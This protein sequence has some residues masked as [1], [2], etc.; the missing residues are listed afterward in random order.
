MKVFSIKGFFEILV[1]S[2]LSVSLFTFHYNRASYQLQNRLRGKTVNQVTSS[3]TVENRSSSAASDLRRALTSSKARPDNLTSF[4]ERGEILDT[5]EKPA[6]RPGM[7]VRSKLLKT[8]FK[9]PYVRTQETVVK[10]TQFNTEEILDQAVMVGDHLL[11]HLKPGASVAGLSRVAD[12]LGG[13]VLSKLPETETYIVSFEATKA[14]DLVDQMTRY[15]QQSEVVAYVEPDYFVQ[16][17]SVPN[18]SKFGQLWSLNN[19]RQTGGKVD[20]DIDAPEAWDFSTGSH[21]VKVAVID[22]GIDYTHPDLSANIWTNPGEIAQNGI[23]DDNN[24]FI[25]DTRGWNFV[26]RSNDPRD[27]NVH[28]TQ[29]AGVVGAVGNNAYLMA[30]ICWQVSLV[31]IKFLDGEGLGVTSDAAAAISYASK[32]GVD[33]SLCP[34]GSTSFSQVVRDAIAEADMKGILF[35][36]AA[37][38]G[39]VDSQGD[40]NDL[41]PFY[42]AGYDLENIISVGSS[43]HFDKPSFASNYGL[44]SVDVYAPGETIRTTYPMVST[45]FMDGRMPTEFGVSSGTSF[46]ASHVAGVCALVKADKPLLTPNQV[47]HLIIWQSDPLPELVGKCRSE[48]RLNAFRTLRSAASMV[49][50]VIASPS[51]DSSHKIG[52]SIQIQGTVAGLMFQS[53]RIFYRPWDGT[54]NWYAWNEVGS[55]SAAAVDN[56]HLG[57][58]NLAG[59]PAGMYQLKVEAVSSD[60]IIFKEVARVFIDVLAAPTRLL[61]TEMSSSPLQVGLSWRDHSTDESGFKIER[62]T[63]NEGVYAEIASVPAGTITYTDAS[64][65]L[66]SDGTVYYYRVRSWNSD[67]NSFYSNE[68]GAPKPKPPVAPGNFVAIVADETLVELSWEDRS[69]D[70]LYFRLERRVGTFGYSQIATIDPDTTT[71]SDYDVQQGGQYTY[72]LRAFGLGGDSDYSNEATALMPE[73]V[74]S[75]SNLTAAALGLDQIELQWTDNSN[76]EDGFLIQRK[77]PGG[78]FF[79]LV[80]V[81]DSMFVDTGLSPGLKYTY[82]VCAYDSEGQS[83]FSNQVEATTQKAPFAPMN[84]AAV[85][86]SNSQISLTWTDASESEDGF[87]IERQEAD[88]TFVEVAR[89]GANVVSYADEGLSEWTRYFYRVRAFNIGGYSEYSNETSAKTLGAVYGALACGLN[90]SVALDESGNVWV[91]GDNRYGQLGNGTKTSRA[92]PARLNTIASVVEVAAGDSHT[93]AIKADGKVYTWGSNTKGQLGDN[94]KT[95]RK[96]PVLVTNLNSAVQVDGGSS[97]TL[98]LLGDGSV[99]SWGENGTG[100]LG[101]GTKSDRKIPVSVVGLNQVIEIAA[102]GMHGLALRADGAVYAWGHNGQGQLGNGTKQQALIAMQVP[103]LTDVVHI[104]AGASHSL[105]LKSDGT[106]W[107]WGSNDYGQL[108]DGTE[109][110]R[111]VPTKI[112]TLNGIIAIGIGHSHNLAISVNGYVWSWGKNTKG[113]VGDG[114]LLNRLSPTIIGS[115]TQGVSVAGGE[116]HTLGL[117]ADGT[118]WS[119]GLNSSGQLGDGSS[120]NHLVPQPILG[121]DLLQSD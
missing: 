26:S 117:Q 69:S 111:S 61:A 85:S 121:L 37:G 56:G 86:I 44:E 45:E 15:G 80:Q 98:A 108:G 49:D 32:M 103:H 78:V 112:S 21:A 95:D 82:R 42:P 23:D 41:T 91:W 76:N 115:L 19:T 28:G 6:V 5:R 43:T 118:V 58:W 101:D 1:V 29:M 46:A 77:D 92:S 16:S 102:G 62:K 83:R 2:V 3:I 119:W 96:T 13:S 25:D 90:H 63:G 64:P 116:S 93:I 51:Y 60:G 38:N 24:G 4:I 89:V 74:S 70:E 17:L 88:G 72:R 14:N 110:R 57:T 75:P 99:R 9:Y 71:Y 40:N 48:S 67:G 11:I 36:T 106:V 97:F 30:G 39:G 33:I 84:L 10:N 100:Q 79:D 22:T 94:S 65:S 18:D 50:V 87:A 59:L 35:I 54:G 107:V 68:D 104:A 52:A 34:W 105:A 31:P 47:K 81:Q 55:M 66:L 8:N 27:D 114:S 20:A 113:Q 7:V 73:R 53:Y 120:L 109:S 12:K